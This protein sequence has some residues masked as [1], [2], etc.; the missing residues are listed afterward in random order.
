MP[1]ETRYLFDWLAYSFA[2]PDQPIGVAVAIRGRKG[3]GK[4]VLSQFLQ[5]MTGDGTYVVS[6]MEKVLGRFN[7]LVRQTVFLFL[8]EALW[9]GSKKSARAMQNLL[10]EPMLSTEEKGLPVL[11][12]RNCLHVLLASNDDWVVPASGEDE[13]RYC[14][15]DANA[16]LKKEWGFW[17]DIRNKYSLNSF[18]LYNGDS[19][20]EKKH[21]LGLLLGWLI[22]RGQWL[23]SNGWIANN[24]IPQNDALEEQK[25]YSSDPFDLWWAECISLGQLGD[26]DIEEVLKPS[27]EPPASEVFI[28]SQTVR[29]QFLNS[30]IGQQASRLKEYTA[31]S[32]SQRL[33]R[34]L[35]KKM[36]SLKR[37]KRVVPKEKRLE[38]ECN[39]VKSQAWGYVIQLADLKRL[40]RAR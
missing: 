1:E 31:L 20:E 4:G 10:T 18:D 28:W 27:E 32:V 30:E 26:L 7:A 35:A 23:K 5:W 29:D 8:D 22:A 6:D 17:N 3:I 16:G 37:E 14:V 25:R 2:Y 34:F 33:G 36:P 15:L 11:S 40:D 38:I 19:I 12:T 13:R 21:R 9:S 24:S 39:N